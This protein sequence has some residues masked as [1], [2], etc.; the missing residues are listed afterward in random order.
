VEFDVT[1]LMLIINSG[2]IGYW[3]KNRY[4]MDQVFMVFKKA[5]DSVRRELLSDV[6]Y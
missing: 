2:S 6:L 5:Y 4:A 3:R 1:D